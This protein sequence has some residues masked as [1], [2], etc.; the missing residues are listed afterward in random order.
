MRISQNCLEIIKKWEGF[1]LDAYIDPVGIPTIGYGT[2]RYPDGQKVKLG[3]KISEAEAEAFLKFEV[4]GTVESL[5]EILK[6][7]KVSQNQFDAIVSLCYNI[8]VG[9]FKS[10]SVLRFLK[11]GDYKKAGESIDLWN[12]GTVNGVKTVLPGLVKRRKDERDLFEK[13]GS[14][15]TPIET[16]E[17]PQDKVTKLE[18][19]RDGKNNI[20]VAYDEKDKV[21]EILILKSE[22]KED[23][24][25]TIQLYKNA[26]T[27]NFAPKSKAVP[28]GDRIEIGGKA[29]DIPQVKNAPTL[30]RSLLQRGVRDDDPGVTGSDVAELQERLH[31][32]GYY[33]GKVDGIFG[34]ATDNAVRNFQADVLG[35]AEADGKVGKIT[36]GKLWGEDSAPPKPTGKAEPV[37]AEPGKNYLLLTKTA[38]KFP[39]GLFKLKLE[40]IKD[41]QSKDFMFVNSGQPKRQFFRKGKDSVRGSYEPLPEGKWQIGD[42]LWAGGKDVYNG[43]MWQEGIGPAK[44]R[45]DYVPKSGTSRDLILFHMDWNA[46]TRPGTA[47]CVGIAS[48]S[49]FK[50]LV[51]WLRDTDPRD[52]Y[53]DW[54]LGSIKL[55]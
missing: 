43:A 32:L 1:K 22:I 17:S 3:D 15:G 52:L 4:D 13:K 38:T 20:I 45:L 10:S 24:I 41:G 25:S 39:N 36:W 29:D 7:I 40:Y 34:A 48:I 2:I 23:L 21:I 46:S 53:V 51:D 27:F 30:E 31:E 8:G 28:K 42:I 11:E 16:E 47:G 44:I 26:K 54:G 5:N 49:D 50:R 12:K 33:D 55:P 37:K 18:G 14:D 6:E 19:F 35:I 9:A